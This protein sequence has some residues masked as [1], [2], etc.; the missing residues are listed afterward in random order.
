MGCKRAL[1]VHVKRNIV[2]VKNSHVKSFFVILLI[3]LYQIIKD[4]S[5][6][7]LQGRFR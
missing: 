6:V 7:Y 2:S 1:F 5:V 3:F 4:G